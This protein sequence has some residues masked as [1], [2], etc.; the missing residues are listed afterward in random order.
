MR[1]RLL[2][3]SDAASW[4]A[5]DAYAP[6]LADALRLAFDRTARPDTSP[7]EF[8][9]V[10][11][12]L[13]PW[14]DAR[15]ANQQRVRVCYLFARGCEVGREYAPAIHWVDEAL[16]A[17]ARAHAWGEMVELLTV[18]GRLQRALDNYRAAADDLNACLTLLYL[19]ADREEDLDPVF[20]LDLLAHL[21]SFEFFLAH[22]QSALRLVRQAR[23]LIPLVPALP[24]AA[25]SVLWADA[26]LER[27]RGRPERALLL[28][29]TAAD[30]HARE[31]SLSS[32]VR[33]ETFVAEVVLDLVERVPGDG[34]VNR[35]PLLMLAGGHL[36]K[37]ERLA[38][39][40]DDRP[41]AALAKLARV[42]EGRLRGRNDDR[43]GAIE[44]VIRTARRM[45][46]VALHAQALTRLGGELEAAGED[47]RARN[48]WREALTVLE[49]SE[50][51][52]LKHE[53]RRKLLLASEFDLI[54]LNDLGV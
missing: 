32:Q 53:P 1:L 30:I 9:A 20:R 37:A 25:A 10:C 23:R 54:P 27:T 46:N 5:A 21:A 22:Y 7:E 48:C 51:P 50:V 13:A 29:M 44:G 6:P 52:A 11:A 4:R 15:V 3:R 28:A 40:A 8:L 35:A 24:L 26:H 41:G 45:D 49:G 18:R 33:M 31:A 12:I 14:L 17:A 43:V 39:E 36:R 38:R 2:T 42:R 19:H 16:V 34:S 47:E